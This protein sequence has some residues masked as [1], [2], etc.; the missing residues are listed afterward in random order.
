MEK[1]SIEFCIREGRAECEV[2]KRTCHDKKTNI[3]WVSVAD[4]GG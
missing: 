2:Y 1:G 3:K 4:S